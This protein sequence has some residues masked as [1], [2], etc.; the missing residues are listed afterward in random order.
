[1]NSTPI[2]FVQEN[3]DSKP[4][5]YT[6]KQNSGGGINPKAFHFNIDM[7]ITNI[8]TENNKIFISGK[9]KLKKVKLASLPGKKSE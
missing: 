3:S 8:T 9:P 5:H 2:C 4:L 1:M 6:L 7:D